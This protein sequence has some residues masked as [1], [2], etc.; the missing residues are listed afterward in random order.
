MK[1]LAAA[2]SRER[3]IGLAGLML[4]TTARGLRCVYYAKLRDSARER[5]K[6]R[7]QNKLTNALL[8]SSDRGLTV[9]YWQHLNEYAKRFY[10]AKKRRQI[11]ESLMRSTEYG[12]TALYFSKWARWRTARN[13][14][15]K[16]R[17]ITRALMGKSDAGL[18]QIYWHRLLRHTKR[19]KH[20]GHRRVLAATLAQFSDSNLS[21]NCFARWLR[22]LRAHKA[23]RKRREFAEVLSRGSDHLLVALYNKKCIDYMSA[24]RK[25]EL[26]QRMKEL[27]AQF[28]RLADLEADTLNLSEEEIEEAIRQC[29][30]DIDV[31][32]AEIKQLQGLIAAQSEANAALERDI[33]MMTAE[34]PEGDADQRLAWLMRRLKSHGC[35]CRFDTAEIAAAK[36]EWSQEWNFRAAQ[37]ASADALA[38]PRAPARHVENALQTIRSAVQESW[39][40]LAG[41]RHWKRHSRPEP[42]KLW[43]LNVVVF[44]SMAT[45]PKSRQLFKRC[46]SGV[47][48][49]VIAWDRMTSREK[50][51]IYGQK[52]DKRDL[53]PADPGADVE[54]TVEHTERTL[55]RSVRPEV[56]AEIDE[57]FMWILMVCSLMHDYRFETVLPRL[58]SQQ[59]QRVDSQQLGESRLHDPGSPG[60]GRGSPL[61]AAGSPRGL[62]GSGHHSRPAGPLRA[63]RV[64]QRELADAAQGERMEASTSQR[65]T[66]TAG[67][68]SGTQRPPTPAGSRGIRSPPHGAAQSSG[69]SR[70]SPRSGHRSAGS[71][72][73]ADALVKTPSNAE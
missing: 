41:Q 27:D 68:G 73:T 36:K 29:L 55:L 45:D 65:P 21:K 66:P 8:A 11:G 10:A 14:A 61:R 43:P 28:Q 49:L 18:K 31:L 1:W 23:K 58:D 25:A 60:S 26:Q 15:A 69:H 47:A 7:R 19:A 42:G 12:V 38:H 46:H 30:L 35:N 32:E 57:N 3:R 17:M 44:T 13:H 2:R 33:A 6:H 67:R 22:W 52:H 54:G 34:K 48:R 40:N 64:R 9:L 63:R 62:Q 51:V 37:R 5:R 53:K 4:R 24:L 16:R 56:K 70:P 20:A 50:Q 39:D 71:R 59:L 72:G